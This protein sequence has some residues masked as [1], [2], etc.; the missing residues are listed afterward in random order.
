MG[1]NLV[2]KGLTVILHNLHRKCRRESIIHFLHG[3]NEH[4]KGKIKTGRKKTA[5]FPCYDSPLKIVV[6]M[7]P[8]QTAIQ[9]TLTDTSSLSSQQTKLTSTSKCY[10]LWYTIHFVWKHN[11]NLCIFFL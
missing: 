1:F 6:I 4:I 2:F 7:Q 10:W 3:N 5:T 11:L 8:K 9:R